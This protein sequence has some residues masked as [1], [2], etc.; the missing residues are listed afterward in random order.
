MSIIM[1]GAIPGLKY[2]KIISFFP[3]PDIEVRRDLVMMQLTMSVRLHFD[4][5][6]A[7]KLCDF[8][9]TNSG[10]LLHETII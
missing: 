5:N 6:Y 3:R 2:L 4:C 1:F 7:S 9:Q 8:L 10:N